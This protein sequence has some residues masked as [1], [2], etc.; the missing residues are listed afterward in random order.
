[1]TVTVSGTR[2]SLIAARVSGES[3]DL[4]GVSDNADSHELLAVVATVHHE[5]VGETLN[6]G[7]V[8]LAE[9]LGGIATSRV[10]EVDGGAD[11][12]VVAV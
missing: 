5:G 9:A 3:Y 8:G 10:G 1:M 6:D 12:D 4:K 2:L 11:L 7:A